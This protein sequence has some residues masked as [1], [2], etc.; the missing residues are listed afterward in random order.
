MW[1]GS[2]LQR[3]SS[4]VQSHMWRERNIHAIQLFLESD[5]YTTPNLC[6]STENSWWFK[7]QSADVERA[8]KSLPSRST[9]I[10]RCPLFVSFTSFIY[11][12]FFLLLPWGSN[13]T[14]SWCCLR[15]WSADGLSSSPWYKNPP[16]S[17]EVGQ[18]IYVQISNGWFNERVSRIHPRLNG[19]DGNL[20]SSQ[21]IGYLRYL[22]TSHC[23]RSYFNWVVEMIDLSY[24]P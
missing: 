19:V 10:H 23:I 9:V 15:L 13:W 12:W 6:N 2:W 3:N 20:N 14:Q 8:S 24:S 5:L 11:N 1:V 16:I 18:N 22:N 7:T 21:L 4:S 17:T